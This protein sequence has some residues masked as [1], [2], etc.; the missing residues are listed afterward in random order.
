VIPAGPAS[1]SAP[2][3]RKADTWKSTGR[4]PIG[5]PPTSGTNASPV[6][7]SSGPS[8]RIG[9]R[10][11]PVNASGTRDWTVPFG[12]TVTSPPDRL[13]WYPM[14][15][16]IAAVMSTSPTSGAFLI[17]LGPSPSIA[18]TMCLVTAFFDPRTPISPRSGP[19]GSTCHVSVTQTTVGA[20]SARS[21]P[22][23]AA[24]RNR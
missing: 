15:S 24:W 9:I 21:G 12:A 10:F 3:A 2:R 8:I 17:V 13:T 16:S 7:C 20:P 14:A 18:A 22:L 6:R 4:R 1:I 19:D 11:S 5:S 23:R